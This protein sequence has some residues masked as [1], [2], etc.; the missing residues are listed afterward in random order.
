MNALLCTVLLFFSCALAAPAIEPI[1]LSPT[2]SKYDSPADYREQFPERGVWTNISVGAASRGENPFLLMDSKQT[3]WILFGNR[4]GDRELEAY[5]ITV[6][7]YDPKTDLYRWV[8]GPGNSTTYLRD[9]GQ[10]GVPSE[11]SWPGGVIYTTATIDHNDNIWFVTSAELWMFN[12]TSYLFTRIQGLSGET[13]YPSYGTPGQPGQDVYPGDIDGVS[14]VTDSQN[15]LWLYGGYSLS[16]RSFSNQVWH[17]N[18]TSWLW[19]FVSGNN[20]TTTDSSWGENPFLGGRWLPGFDVD[21]DD[22]IWIVGGSGTPYGQFSD[23]WSF[24]TK[25]AQWRLESGS[26]ANRNNGP[27]ITSDD[28]HAGNFPPGK[29]GASLVNRKDG[30]LVLISGGGHIEDEGDFGAQNDVWLFNKTLKQW[31]LIYGEP[32]Q[33]QLFGNFTHYR[34]PGSVMPARYYHGGANGL[35]V[36]GD[37]FVQGGTNDAQSVALKDMWLIPFDQCASTTS[38]KC[39]S[40]AQCIEEMIGYS[41]SC[42]E[43][44]VGD[45]FEC[46]AVVPP[47]APIEQ[48]PVGAP[49]KTNA[50]SGLKLVTSS[51]ILSLIS[52]VIT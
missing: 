13:D 20:Y 33:R 46:T 39:S 18:T 28:F 6:W 38:H 5:L 51:F 19:T 11:D 21:E 14:L 48:Q 7:N 45:G 12:T 27:K 43:G 24:D 26:A 52:L 40:D 22:R 17:F 47:Q 25:T 49:N 34:T 16:I 23:V 4:D 50:A 37:V 42:N 41:C 9:P 15:N 8:A 2:N 44:F 35:N 32:S 10:L 29:E 30:T 3:L 31:K 1:W 36:D